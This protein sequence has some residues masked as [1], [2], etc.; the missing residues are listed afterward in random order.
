MKPVYVAYVQRHLHKI[1]RRRVRNLGSIIT[2]MFRVKHQ[3]RLKNVKIYRCKKSRQV[4][5]FLIAIL[6]Q[7]PLMFAGLCPQTYSQIAFHL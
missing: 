3:R 1:A 6:Q 7:Q 5:G 2:E 4:A